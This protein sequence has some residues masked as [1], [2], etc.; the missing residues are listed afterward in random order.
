MHNFQNVSQALDILSAWNST[1]LKFNTELYLKDLY[2]SLLEFLN[3]NKFQDELVLLKHYLNLDKINPRL[4]EEYI[5][6][7]SDSLTT[8]VVDQVLEREEETFTPQSIL[9]LYKTLNDKL[10]DSSIVLGMKY[11]GFGAKS[12]HV[13]EYLSYLDDTSITIYYHPAFERYSVNYF[14]LM[15]NLGYYS[16]VKSILRRIIYSPSNLP[17]SELGSSRTVKFI[18]TCCK[19]SNTNT[20][21]L[22]NF[23]SHELSYPRIPHVDTTMMALQHLKN[24]KIS[25]EQR[26][27]IILEYTEITDD[28]SFED[29]TKKINI[30]LF[31]SSIDIELRNKFLTDLQNRLRNMSFK[32]IEKIPD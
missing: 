24:S 5:Y 30:L 3:E 14:P 32:N 12:C 26:Q 6:K 9:N 8:R 11:I 13:K 4:S 22:H 29:L 10:E 2:E 31:D 21:F 16:H 25:P 17:S 15:L 7:L 20:L 27:R 1:N 18:E 23:I 19:I 28:I